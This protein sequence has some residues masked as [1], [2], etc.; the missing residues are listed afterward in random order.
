MAIIDYKSSLALCIKRPCRQFEGNL[1]C[2][3]LL[4][5]YAEVLV[6]QIV[7][8]ALCHRYGPIELLPPSAKQK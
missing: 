4:R 6:T 1:T 3:R 7:H 8:A 5:R 2:Q